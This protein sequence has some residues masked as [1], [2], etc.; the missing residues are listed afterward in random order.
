MAATEQTIKQFNNLGNNEYTY[1][2][3]TAIDDSKS[4][5]G[6]NTYSVEII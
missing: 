1:G 6:L 2:F 3:S 5:K 4:P